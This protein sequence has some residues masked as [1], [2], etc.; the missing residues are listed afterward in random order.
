MT[1]AADQSGISSPI[2]G[3]V[4]AVKVQPDQPVE[5]G[6]VLCIVEA[7]KMENEVVAPRAGL[8]EAIHVSPGEAVQA[9]T[10]L[11]SLKA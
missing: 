2:Q 10:L 9:G 4:V 5:A 1:S 7:M 3:T 6:Q 8:I 11:A